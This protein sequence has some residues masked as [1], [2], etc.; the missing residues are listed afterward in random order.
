M[1]RVR[2]SWM[3]KVAVAMVLSW[4][5]SSF[6]APKSE[7]PRSLQDTLDQQIVPAYLRGDTL[8]LVTGLSELI[9]RATPERVTLIDQAL[10]DEKIPP[11]R[12]LLLDA[13]LSLVLQGQSQA[14]PKPHPR[15]MLLTIEP[16]RKTVEATL[17]AAHQVAMLSDGNVKATTF[18]EFEEA[19]WDAHVYRNR[20]RTAG[21]L[22]D[23][24]ETM[25]KEAKELRPSLVPAAQRELLDTDFARLRSQLLALNDRLEERSLQL[26]LRR[27]AFAA[28][29]HTR[30]ATFTERLRAAFVGDLDGALLE[31][32]FTTHA[33]HPFEDASLR[34][35][36]VLRDIQVRARRVRQ[37]SGDLVLKGRLLYQ[38]LHWW[39]RGRYGQGPEGNGMLKSSLALTHPAA[40]FAL[41]M[42]TETPH[43]TDPYDTSQYPIPEID[44]RHHQIWQ[45]EYRRIAEQN[46]VTEKTDSTTE[47]RKTVTRF[48]RFY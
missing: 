33:D 43:P 11:V 4:G 22:A 9:A 29:M 3:M 44:R 48:D 16:V 47:S 41:Y 15:E 18:D 24:G 20:L 36:G 38:G 39:L 1:V 46:L 30:N 28:S 21:M 14:L 45:F 42:P 2:P 19:F 10:A 31:E 23:Y 25:V 8:W 12:Q 6:A 7:L 34:A 26:R 35:P 27:L 5:S 17:E 37:E 13:R 32:F 40:L